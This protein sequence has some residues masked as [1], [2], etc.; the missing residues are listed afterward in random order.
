MFSRLASFCQTSRLVVCRVARTDG[1]FLEKYKWIYNGKWTRITMQGLEAAREK[2]P[3]QEQWKT[4]KKIMENTMRDAIE[5]VGH[6][7]ACRR[8]AWSY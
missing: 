8:I 5:A 1:I 4:M 7:G 3:A 2:P 6:A